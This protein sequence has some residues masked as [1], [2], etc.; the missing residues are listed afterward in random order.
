MKKMKFISII[1]FISLISLSIVAATDNNTQLDKTTLTQDNTPINAIN[2]TNKI[3]KQITTTN[4]NNDILDTKNNK[5]IT[6]TNPIPEKTS[7]KDY[8]QLNNQ[9]NLIK[10]NGTSDKNYSIKLTGTTYNFTD[11]IVWDGTPTNL[12]LIGGDNYYHTKIMLDGMRSCPLFGINSN[13]TLTLINVTLINGVSSAILNYGTLNFINVEVINNTNIVSYHNSIIYGGASVVYAGAIYN[14]GTINCYNSTFSGNKAISYDTQVTYEDIE[15]P[16]AIAFSYGGAIYNTGTINCYNSTFNNNL[17]K[18]NTMSANYLALYEPD[19][20]AYSY[21][22]AIYNQGTLTLVDSIL[23]SNIANS[24]AYRSESGKSFAYGGAIHNNGTLNIENSVL[25]NNSVISNPYYA[26]AIGGAISNNKIMNIKNSNLTGNKAVTN[27]NEEI[28][29]ETCGG[30]IYNRGKTSTNNLKLINNTAEYGG[31]IYTTKYMNIANSHFVNNNITYTGGAIYTEN[32][33][34][35]TNSVFINNAE[36]TIYSSNKSC[37]YSIENNWWGN[38]NPNWNKTLQNIEAPQSWIYLDVTT[39]K[40]NIDVTETTQIICNFN[41]KTNGKNITQYN[42]KILDNTPITCSLMNN[43]GTTTPQT[44]IVQNSTSTTIFTGTENGIETI[45]IKTYDTKTNLSTKITIK[46]APT[47][48]KITYITPNITSGSNMTIQAKITD[49]NK[50]PITTGEVVIK[51]NGKTLKD[52]YGASI[53]I[54]VINGTINYTYHIPENYSAKTYNITVKYLRNNQYTPS[55]Q[56]TNFTITKAPTSTK[57]TY[58]TPNITS[59]SN[60]TIQAKITDKNKQPITTGEVVIKINGKTLK[61]EYGA[62]I[63]IPVIN[64]TINYTYHIPENY[65]AK[66]YNITVKYLR[67]NQYTPSEQTRKFTII[68]K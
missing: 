15:L 6:N 55:E 36:N 62:S 54:P 1:L 60:M 11:R 23:T 41:Y 16:P 33:L 37:N 52:E 48:T 38:N 12:T 26:Y 66:T 31:A 56:T 8:T 59:G 25:N 39:T 5:Q 67:N 68:K 45:N 18:A 44:A 50:Q 43:L 58:I 21:G 2:E 35:I 47:S 61:D 51:I 53:K 27:S 24:E 57:I 49:K 40:N 22:G 4:K 14:T 3:E 19:S 30:A 34:K 46:A 64:G 29:V 7:A 32:G 13:H 20:I 10:N 65:S 42:N 17:A 63:K 28:R 9:I